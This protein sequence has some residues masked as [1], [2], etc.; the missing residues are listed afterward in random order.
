MDTEAFLDPEDMD[1]PL[2][3]QVLLCWKISRFQK[4]KMPIFN[5]WISRSHMKNLIYFI[6]SICISAKPILF[7]C[8][9]CHKD[10]MFLYNAYVSHEDYY[11]W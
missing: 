7:S 10:F 3:E 8:F 4:K 5:W 1:I 9:I 11:L 6:W 2:S